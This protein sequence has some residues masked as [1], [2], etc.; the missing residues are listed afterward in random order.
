MSILTHLIGNYNFYFK[1]IDNKPGPFIDLDT[2]LTIGEHQ[3][4]HHWTLGQRCCIGGLEKPYFIAKKI[5]L[6][7]E[8]Y[9]VSF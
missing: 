5:V 7:N 9:V 6:T 8:I 4:I 3:G 1:Y 2:G